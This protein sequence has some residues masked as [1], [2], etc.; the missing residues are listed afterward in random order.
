M[1]KFYKIATPGPGTYKLPSDFGHYETKK[2]N[3]FGSVNF[4]SVQSPNSQRSPNSV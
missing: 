4:S 1:I 3:E 2:K